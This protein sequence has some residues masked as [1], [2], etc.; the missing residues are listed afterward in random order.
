MPHLHRLKSFLF[1]TTTK[2]PK[3]L[4]PLF[5]LGE[6]LLCALIILKVPYTEIDWQAYMQQVALYNSGERDYAAI[7]GGTGPLVYPAAH[8]YVYALLH[9]LTDSGRDVRLAQWLFMG[10]YL[11]TLGVVMAVYRK[12]Q[13][14]VYILP[15]LCLS[16]RL[17]SIYVL[18]LFND[19]VAIFFLFL[20]IFF[21]QK[22]SWT[23]G[24]IAYSFSVGVKMNTLLVLPAVGLIYLFSLGRDAAIRRAMVMAQVQVLLASPFITTF[25]KS[26]LSRA[27]EFTRQFLYQWTVNWRFVPESVFLSKGFSLGLLTAHAGLLLFFFSTRWSRPAARSLS[28]TISLLLRPA[29]GLEERQI[30]LRVTPRYILTTIL[31]ANTI[32][33]LC[34]RSLHYQFYSWLAWGA[35]YLLWKSGLGPLWVVVLWAAQEWAWNVFPSTNVSS[36]VV[37]GALA[38]TLVGVWIGAREEE[39]G[40]RAE[41]GG[42]KEK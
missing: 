29:T 5:L 15:L 6:S 2:F 3:W 24:S 10:L 9:K 37:V 42:K 8:V 11:A 13:A 35:P 18:R 25:P 14:P 30:S 26:Y 28:H 38:A 31:T 34:A 17:H 32:G 16:K 33:M 19:P 39:E 40:K 22:R 7:K 36:A 12:A 27:F 4:I 41:S 20:A 23:L 21:W 1:S